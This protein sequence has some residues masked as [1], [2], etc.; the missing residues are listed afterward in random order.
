VGAHAAAELVTWQY[1][2]VGRTVGLLELAL[3]RRDEAERRLREA[4]ALRERIDARAFLA[5]ARHDLA[6]YCSPPPRASAFSTRRATPPMNS[7]CRA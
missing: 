7:A 2:P 3:G 5:I 1:C 4:V 6:S